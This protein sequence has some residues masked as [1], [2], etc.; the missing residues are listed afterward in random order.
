MR[1]LMAAVDRFCYSHPRFGIPNLML[2]IVI[3]NAV[4]WFFSMMDR[5]GNLLRLLYFSPARIFAGEVW[6]LVSFILIPESSGIWLLIFLYFYYFIGSTLEREWG[7]AKFTLYYFSGVLLAILYGL[8]LYVITGN[9]YSITTGYVNLSMFFAFATLFPET[10]VLLFFII[11][12]KIKWLAYLNAAY[13][14]I[15]IFTTRFPLNLLPVVAI[16]NYLVFCGSWLFDL[17]RPSTIRQKKRT[18]DFKREAQRIR[19]EQESA[20]YRF[21]CAVCGRT[22]RE[23][24]ELEFRYC[25]RCEG[26]HCFCSDHINSHVH[27]TS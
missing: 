15:G 9:S 20:P 5:S 22:D 21:K 24:P 16:L 23:H 12:I 8:L 3:G 27:F 26:Y 4:V 11:P 13:F 10:T 14:I 19:R 18:V 17:I 7:T 1:K 25:S 6:R 2:Y